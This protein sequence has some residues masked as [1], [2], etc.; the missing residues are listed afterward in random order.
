MLAAANRASVQKRAVAD[1]QRS[2]DQEQQARTAELFGTAE[3]SFKRVTEKL[4]EGIQTYATSAEVLTDPRLRGSRAFNSMASGKAFIAMLDGAQIGLDTPQRGPSQPGSLPFTV[5]AESVIKV[6]RPTPLNGW[7][8]RGHSL[9]FCDAVEEGRFAWYE[10]AF[11]RMAFGGGGASAT[12]P[13]ELDGIDARDALLP[14]LAT[15]QLAWDFQEIDRSD[16]SEFINRWLGWFGQAVT[17]S[18]SVRP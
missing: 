2:T 7:S 18:F 6:T 1:A 4:L 10:L 16:L 14:G 13:F 5:V 12:D 3:Q 15:T 11:T 9:W 17:D 8:G